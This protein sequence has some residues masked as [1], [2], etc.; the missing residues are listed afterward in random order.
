MKLGALNGRDVLGLNRSK[1]ASSNN[2]PNVL[3]AIVDRT[4]QQRTG[5]EQLGDCCVYGIV[6]IADNLEVFLGGD[7]FVEHGHDEEDSITKTVQL[8]EAK[9]HP[10]K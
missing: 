7:E 5:L 10:G 2:G 3:L 4:Q 6:D 8:G 9:Y 1:L